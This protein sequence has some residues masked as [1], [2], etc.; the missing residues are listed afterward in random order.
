MPRMSRTAVSKVP[1]AVA[2]MTWP[3]AAPPAGGEL[4]AAAAAAAS[5]V[6]SMDMRVFVLLKLVLPLRNE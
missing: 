2:R 6:G 1:A 4:G 5:V 3:I